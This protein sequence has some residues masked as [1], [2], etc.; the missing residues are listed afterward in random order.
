MVQKQLTHGL[1][2]IFS[3]IYHD[4]WIWREYIAGMYLKFERIRKAMC[5]HE[6]PILCKCARKRGNA[7]GTPFDMNDM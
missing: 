7:F 5:S 2:L 3:K 6:F 1:F 4:L